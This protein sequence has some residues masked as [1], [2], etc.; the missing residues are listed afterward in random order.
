MDKVTALERTAM[1]YYCYSRVANSHGYNTRLYAADYGPFSL[2]SLQWPPP[3]S[4]NF[5]EAEA[6]SPKTWVSYTG[7]ELRITHAE[8][9]FML[10]QDRYWKLIFLNTNSVTHRDRS[11]PIKVRTTRLRLRLSMEMLRPLLIDIL[12]EHHPE[13]V[14]F[15]RVKGNKIKCLTLYKRK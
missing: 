2:A 6:Y 13:L 4:G 1:A 14:D 10:F 15:T 8:K 7:A 9:S 5:I 3:R 12:H 11:F